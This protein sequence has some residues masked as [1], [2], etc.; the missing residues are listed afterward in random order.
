VLSHRRR[1]RDYFGELA[2][3][4]GVDDPDDV[5][6]QWMLLTEGAIVTALVED[7]RAATKR[8]RRAAARLVGAEPLR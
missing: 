6:D 4:A 2:V 1:S 8:A 5:S 7:D 3:A